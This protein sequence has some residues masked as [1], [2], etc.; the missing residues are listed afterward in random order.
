MA[1]HTFTGMKKAGLSAELE[2]F[3]PDEPDDPDDDAP[4]SPTSTQL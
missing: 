1:E 4:I 3:D 2:P